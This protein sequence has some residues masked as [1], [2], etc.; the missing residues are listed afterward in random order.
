[1]DRILLLEKRDGIAETVAWVERTLA[2]YQAAITDPERHS[3]YREKMAREVEI[4]MSYL[5][6][7]RQAG[8]DAK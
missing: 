4:L 5:A 7:H 8:S 6:E 1:M 2:I 3:M